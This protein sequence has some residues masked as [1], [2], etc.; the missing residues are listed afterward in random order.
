M[1]NE[2]VYLKVPFIREESI[3][4][5]FKEG[6]YKLIKE[7]PEHYLIQH[8]NGE[9]IKLSKSRFATGGELKFRLKPETLGSEIKKAIS[10]RS[11]KAVAKDELGRTKKYY[12]YAMETAK[13]NPDFVPVAD[14]AKQ[15]YEVAKEEYE[16][17][18]HGGIIDSIT[19][20]LTGKTSLKD[21]FN[22]TKY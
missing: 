7:Y 3:L 11:K 20:F 18:A 16:K 17:F 4:P 1:R 21:I 12:E 22:P 14:K 6:N 10:D 8:P 19:N 2:I 9:T 5:D 15:E 13:E